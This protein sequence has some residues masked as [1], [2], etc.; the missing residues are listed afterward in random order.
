MKTSNFYLLAALMLLFTMCRKSS[1]SDI[2]LE[3]PSILK[4]YPTIVKYINL[5]S[6]VIES[7]VFSLRIKDKTD[8]CVELKK[9]RVLCNNVEMESYTDLIGPYYIA[10]TGSLTV[11]DNTLYTFVVELADGEQYSSNVFVDDSYLKFLETPSS[12]I[13]TDEDSLTISWNKPNDD[14]TSQ[15]YWNIFLN[16][17]IN[18]GDK[19]IS[20]WIDVTDSNYYKFPPSFFTYEYDENIVEKLRIEL[21]SEKEG[22]I[23]DNF[24]R[25]R[26]VA[27]FTIIKEITIE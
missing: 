26:I 20:G 12:W 27:K 17:T 7:H 2:E 9:G 14:Y 22:Q 11:T 21:E 4:V 10:P 5:D 25:G 6:T 19:I 1:L 3:D 24:Y 18:S 15:I 23:N 13:W 16:D 8:H